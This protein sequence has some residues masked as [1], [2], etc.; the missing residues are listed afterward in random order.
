MQIKRRKPLRLSSEITGVEGVPL[1]PVVVQVYSQ[2]LLDNPAHIHYR[3]AQLAPAKQLSG[4]DAAVTRLQQAVQTQ[5]RILIAG[6][7]DADGATSTVLCCLMLRTLGAQQVDYVV[8]N[9]FDFGY[10]LS[11]ELVDVAANTKQPDVIITVDNGISSVSG[12]Q[13]ANELGI[14][15]VITDHHLPGHELP[16]AVAIV[17][18]NVAGD[19]FPSKHLAG[20][21]VA[22][23]LMAALFSR[24]QAANSA[25]QSSL[26]PA[27][28]LDLVALG[29]VADVVRLDFNNRI[30]VAQGLARIRAG[31][32]R[33]GITA[34]LQVAGR[35]PEKI[36]A[37]DCGFAIGPRLNAAGR[38][39]DMAVGIECLL[40]DDMPKAL[41][42]A[43]QLDELNRQRRDIQADMQNDALLMVDS[44][45][46]TNQFGVTVF[47]NDWH[48]GVVGLVAGK[49]KEKLHRPVVAFA[50]ES[51]D[52]SNMLK[53]SARSIAGFHIRDALERLASQHPNMITKFGGHAMAAGLSLPAEQLPA[54]TQAFDQL[55]QEW[56]A[57]E[58]LEQV[59]Y[60]DGELVGDQ[61]S[62]DSADAL[63]QAGPWGQGFP[64][65]VFDGCYDVVNSRIVGEK[66]VKLKL[67]TGNKI[68][69]A[70]WFF[71]PEEHLVKPPQPQ[72]RWQVAYKLDAN[73][74]LGS[75]TL[76]LIIETMLPV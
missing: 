27:D 39:D 76:Q 49:L 32:C 46:T 75:T 38:I 1:H 4:L 53:G 20:V 15:V 67:H 33:P 5:Q 58:Q 65:P 10:G 54:F 44:V 25:D 24:M 74:Y 50:L 19:A 35:D 11:P 16:A 55:A 37:S 31:R 14:D 71:A 9:R 34:L 41:Q 40:T 26:K 17:N 2:R 61:L 52:S 42:L 69:D 45:S 6:D 64:E 29:T 3:L 63:K 12:V 59:I 7:F 30:L 43:R 62:L 36:T 72:S 48:A 56:L 51:N 70:I 60:T 57:P 28:L 66:H 13:R 18:P 8:P 47:Q 22:F 21:G 23:Y 73:D 68:L